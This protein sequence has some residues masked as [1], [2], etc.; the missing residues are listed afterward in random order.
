MKAIKAAVV[1]SLIA[2]TIITVSFSLD[3]HKAEA[4]DKKEVTPATEKAKASP[5]EVQKKQEGI[6]VVAYYFHGNVRCPTCMKLEEY[7]GEA[8]NQGFS[9]EI[10]KGSLEF[11]SVNIDEG[12]NSH[13]VQDYQL[14]TRSLVISKIENGKEVKWK[15]LDMIWNLVRDHD[16]YIEYVKEETKKMIEDK[17]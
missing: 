6:K 7:S 17:S 9:D 5:A 13:F 3:G 4:S 8:I 16:K 15:N 1:L 14:V 10:K 12:S 11:K 2:V